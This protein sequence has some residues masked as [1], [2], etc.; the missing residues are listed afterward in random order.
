MTIE[1]KEVVTV[2]TTFA[3]KPIADRRFD[4]I[5]SVAGDNSSLLVGWGETEADAVGDL[6]GKSVTRRLKSS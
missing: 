4:W 2:V 6:V 5:A 3:R 1:I